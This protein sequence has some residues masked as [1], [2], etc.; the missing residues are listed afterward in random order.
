MKKK[1][2]NSSIYRIMRHRIILDFWGKKKKKKKRG[3]LGTFGAPSPDPPDLP[4][5]WNDGILKFSLAALAEVPYPSFFFCLRRHFPFLLR[6]K[7]FVE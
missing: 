3:F 4:N 5:D 7:G 6:K 1:Q 2:G